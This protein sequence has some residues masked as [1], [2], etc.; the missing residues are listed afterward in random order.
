MATKQCIYCGEVKDEEEFRTYY[1]RQGSRYKHCR[2]CERIEARRKYLCRKSEL[3]E[4]ESNELRMIEDLYASRRRAGLQAPGQ[5]KLVAKP[6]VL[7]MVSKE[8]KGLEE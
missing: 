1:N 6:S 5:T 2:S 3:T 7:E 8:I 4:A